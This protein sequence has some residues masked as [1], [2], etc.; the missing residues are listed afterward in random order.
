MFLHYQYSSLQKD[1]DNVS[2]SAFC[3]MCT[4]LDID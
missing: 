4:S 3:D 2:I 1:I